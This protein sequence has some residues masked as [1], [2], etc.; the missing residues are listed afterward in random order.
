MC[1][2]FNG[3]EVTALLRGIREDL[4]KGRSWQGRLGA[5][6]LPVGPSVCRLSASLE[7][8]WGKWDES[9]ETSGRIRSRGGDLE[10]SP[11]T[12]LPSRLAQGSQT[13]CETEELPEAGSQR[14]STGRRRP[15]PRAAAGALG[16]RMPL[17]RDQ[18]QA[19]WR[20]APGRRGEWGCVLLDFGA[21]KGHF[22]VTKRPT[23]KWE[24]GV[25]VARG[26]RSC[27]RR[28]RPGCGPSAGKI[29]RAS[30][31]LSACATTAEPGFHHERGHPRETPV[32][33]SQREGQ[34]ATQAQHSQ[35]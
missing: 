22:Q 23:R 12:R 29:R 10:R 1:W 35:R 3:G 30:E 5:V 11:S 6:K 15:R 28:R 19:P 16:S 24:Q 14:L 7:G 33:R 31:Q 27:L 34:A 25:P 2:G 18:P 20:Q 32:P 8:F 17:N 13:G 21:G 4:T 9:A 26:R